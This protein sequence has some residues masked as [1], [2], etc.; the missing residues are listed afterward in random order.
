MDGAMLV[1][2]L[3]RGATLGMLALVPLFAL[4]QKPDS[5]AISDL[6]KES[7]AHAAL[8]QQDAETLESYSHTNI[9]S[10][11][12]ANSLNAIRDHANDLIKDVNQLSS[13]REEGSPWQQETI[14]RVNPLLHEM[15][16]NLSTT[17]A[18]FNENKNRI[19]MAPF[20]DYVKANRELMS[21]TSQLISDSVEYGEI[22]AKKTALEKTLELSL[23]ARE[24]E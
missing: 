10:V 21:R 7:E 20:L 5:T 6:L 3:K 12:H 17:I 24:N 1:A 16:D 19:Q 14:D 13:M 9:S 8:A 15:A 11:S 18:H 2:T 23:A 4:A 22:R